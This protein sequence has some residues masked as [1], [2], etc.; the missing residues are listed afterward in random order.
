M[1]GVISYTEPYRY[2]TSAENPHD[3]CLAGSSQL[4]SGVMFTHTHTH[5]AFASG[6]V[7]NGSCKDMRIQLVKAV[8]KM[9][10]FQLCIFRFGSK[11]YE[12]KKKNR[13]VCK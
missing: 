12:Q 11:K 10:D 7:G 1:K 9:S 2:L 6:P 5:T 3:N 13:Q 8:L 4:G